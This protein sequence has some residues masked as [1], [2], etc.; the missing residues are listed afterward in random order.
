MLKQE[1][2]GALDNVVHLTDPASKVII[3]S[4][5]NMIYNIAQLDFSSWAQYATEQISQRLTQSDERYQTSALRALK[6]IFQ[7]FEFEIEK[8]KRT[9]LN[10]LVDHFFPQLEQLMGQQSFQSSANYTHMMTIIAKI[11]FI[12]VQ[13]SFRSEFRF[14]Y[15]FNFVSLPLLAPGPIALTHFS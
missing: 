14:Y 8:E 4:I 2:F 15:S 13:V 7:A 5:E 9:V 3:S 12:S 11:F 1:I 10:Q 6:S